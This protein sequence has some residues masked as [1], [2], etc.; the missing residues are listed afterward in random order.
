[1]T[2]DLLTQNK[3]QRIATAYN[4][5]EIAGQFIGLNKYNK[6]I[7]TPYLDSNKGNVKNLVRD[8]D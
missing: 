3:H 5:I 4:E 6:H 2:Q 7:S 1:M 8:A